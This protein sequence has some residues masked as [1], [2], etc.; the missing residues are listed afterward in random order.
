MPEELPWWAITY[1]DDKANP[2]HIVRWN[3]QAATED[4]ARDA[5]AESCPGSELKSVERWPFDPDERL[6]VSKTRES[7]DVR[8]AVSISSITEEDGNFTIHYFPEGGGFQFIASWEEFQER[9][10]RYLEGQQP[11]EVVKKEPHLAYFCFD[12]GPSILG[13]TWGG[14]W[15][16][17]G[18]PSLEVN[19]L[20]EWMKAMPDW[21][22]EQDENT[23]K[24]VGG[25][26]FMLGDSEDDPDR[27]EIEP[28][29][30]TYQGQD[31]LVYGL[32]GSWCWNQMY[33]EE[34]SDCHS[35]MFEGCET[36]KVPK[37]LKK[38]HEDAIS[39]ARK[40]RE[41]EALT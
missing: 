35:D 30:I 26:L 41:E 19:S 37:E 3:C 39:Q 29:A 15:N 31:Y 16:G 1:S 10:Q 18:M 17:W 21:F 2:H 9:Y 34:L 27:Y 8:G 11:Y 7:D 20:K 24:W 25:K 12:D 36:A 6:W 22:Q 38:R 14:L 32:G 40:E 33:V 28:V 5:W 4:D 13:F 23:L